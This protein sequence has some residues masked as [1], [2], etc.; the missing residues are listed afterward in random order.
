MAR[1]RNEVYQDRQLK[2]EAVLQVVS[3][4]SS[5]TVVD[6]SLIKNDFPPAEF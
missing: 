6:M 4:L 2:S 5:Y 1:Q 3:D